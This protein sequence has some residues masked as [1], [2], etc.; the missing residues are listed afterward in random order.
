MQ[1]K[2]RAFDLAFFIISEIIIF[3]VWPYH[4]A[5]VLRAS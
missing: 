5:S 2:S 3:S 4:I 1:E